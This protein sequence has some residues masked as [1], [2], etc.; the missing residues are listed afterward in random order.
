MF[1]FFV[2]PGKRVGFSYFS[3]TI[4]SRVGLEFSVISTLLVNIKSY[5]TSTIFCLHSVLASTQRLVVLLSSP[6]VQTVN[7]SPD[8]LAG[9]NLFQILSITQVKS[10]LFGGNL[11]MFS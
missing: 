9:F 11:V 10:S 3:G 4:F 7:R 2:G 1:L 5:I 6:I 8:L